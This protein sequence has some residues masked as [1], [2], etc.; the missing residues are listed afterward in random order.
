MKKSIVIF[1][2]F[3]II[4]SLTGCD[5]FASRDNIIATRSNTIKC[6]DTAEEFFTQNLE[7]FEEI[8]PVMAE[9]DFVSI[10]YS[11]VTYHF[12]Q[13]KETVV[14]PE[15][16]MLSESDIETVIRFFEGSDYE[17]LEMLKVSSN[18]H[19]AEFC[20][21]VDGQ[22]EILIIKNPNSRHTPKTMYQAFKIRYLT[23]DWLMLAIDNK[24]STEELFEI[25][26][27]KNEISEAL[28]ISEE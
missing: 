2:I 20:V 27:S 21:Y 13:D 7:I 8:A 5:F 22:F 19:E 17:Q 14:I 9:R 11:G 23:D 16:E 26:D 24:M 18:G 25:Y 4:V 1:T 28:N 15:H 6:M 12:I 3:C 10:N